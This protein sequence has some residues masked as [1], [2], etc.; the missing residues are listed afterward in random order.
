MSAGGVTVALCL[1]VY[2]GDGDALVQGISEVFAH[3]ANGHA[4]WLLGEYRTT[5]W[6]YFFPVVLAV[7]TPLAFLALVAVGVWARAWMPL[8]CAGA[9]LLS[10]MPSRIDLGVRHVLV[11]YPFLAMAAGMAVV[12]AYRGGV[13]PYLGSAVLTGLLVCESASAGVDYLSYFNALAGDHPERVLAESDLDWGQDIRRLD[14]QLRHLGAER[15]WLAY[16]GS[17]DPSALLSVP[18]APLSWQAFPS[19]YVAVSVHEQTIGLAMGNGL[20]WLVA[21]RKPVAMAG[22]SIAIYRVE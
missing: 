9:L 1:L 2:G 5:G 12:R 3:N 18:W 17:A 11:I 10:V 13:L 7:K 21:G 15:V 19:G 8:V 20:G 22:K 4:S 16:F 6:W 14:V